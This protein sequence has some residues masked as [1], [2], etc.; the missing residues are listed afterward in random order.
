MR[1]LSFMDNVMLQDSPRTPN[2]IYMVCVYDP[3]TAPGDRP[4]FERTLEKVQSSLASAPSLRRKLVTVPFGLDRPYWIED[5]DFDLEFHVRHIALPKP[6]DWRQFCL[7]VARLHARPLDLS[8]PP[9]EMTVIDGLDGTGR[10]P[11]GCFGTVL[12]VHHAAI[13]GVSG[14]ELLNAIHDLAPDQADAP[15]R[16]TWK[17]DPK[18]STRYLLSRAG[19]HA[20]TNPVGTVRLITASASPLARSVGQALISQRRPVKIPRTRFNAPVSAHRVFD[21]ATCSLSDLKRIK[22]AVPGATINDVCLSIVGGAMCSYLSEAGEPPEYPLVSMVPVSTRTPDQAGSGGNQVSAMRVTMHTHITDPLGRVAAIRATTAQKKA[23]QAGVAIPVLLDIAQLLPGALIGASI[24][25]MSA[26]GSRAPVLVNTIVTN[27]PGPSAPL[28]FLGAKL[29]HFTGGGPLLD[30]IGLFH[31]VSSYGNI[32]TFMV[33][34]DR[35]ML[36][37]P[38]VYVGHLDHSICEH[39]AAAEAVEYASAA[40]DGRRSPR[41]A[42]KAHRDAEAPPARPAS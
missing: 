1:Q 37:D 21:E 40:H 30:G 13:D 41:G 10:F 15:V 42:T 27:V 3:S 28:Y 19:L 5:E 24:R 22:A 2:H 34:A 38:T 8:R 9:W 23:A 25:A 31:C 11:P 18:P 20:V 29:V 33:T 32:F 26:L 12:K 35:E 16:D 36:P 4:T 17:P 7:Q 6:G 14:V 39:V